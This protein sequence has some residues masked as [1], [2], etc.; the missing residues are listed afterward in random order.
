MTSLIQERTVYHISTGATTMN[1]VDAA[2]AISN[3]PREWSA[4]PWDDEV[5]KN[6]E[7][8][9]ARNEALNAVSVVGALKQE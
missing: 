7:A 2:A 8:T 4:V 3:H 9:I 5:V 1:G 6:V